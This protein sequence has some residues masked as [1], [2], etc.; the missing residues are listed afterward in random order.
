MNHNYWSSDKNKVKV[1]SK[2]Q[3]SP[4]K[5]YVNPEIK[6]ISTKIT[7]ED[8]DFIPKYSSKNNHADLLANLKSE[9][10][11]TSGSLESVDCGIEIETPP[12]Y[13][14]CVE[15]SVVGVFLTLQDYKKIKVNLINL[16]KEEII[17]QHKQTIGKIWIEPVY[18]FDWI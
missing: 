8:E 9:L 11:L 1:F 17:L 2:L 12:G 15:S 7:C 13:K 3:P 5:G 6:K 14:L 18:F 16:T 4:A 10:V